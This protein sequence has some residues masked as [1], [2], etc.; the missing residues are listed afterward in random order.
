MGPEQILLVLILLGLTLYAVFGGADFGAGIWEFHT[1]FA[2]TERERSL[3]YRAV[4][5]V[6]EANHVWLIFVL[7]TLHSG[8]PRAFAAAGRALWV[9]L[10]FAMIGI[11]FRG[12]SFAFRSYADRAVRQRAVW[13][14]V[15]ALASIA[16]PFFLGAIVGAIASGRLAVTA[17]G[18]F[19]GNYLTGWISPLSIFTAFFAVG[20]CAYLAAVF[21]IR[22]AV[23]ASAADLVE[24]WRRRALVVAVTIGMLAAAGL[25]YVAA[26]APLLWEGFRSRA[27]PLVA[28][29]FVAGVFSL[30]AIWR[31]RFMAAD[32]GASFVVATVVWGWGVAQYPLIIP[33]TI[34]ID[35]AKGPA[36]VLRATVWAIAVGT[37]LIIPSLGFLLYLFKGK[38]P[39][40][41]PP[42]K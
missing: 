11:V 16:A 35:T 36:A 17:D 30:A 13:D 9:P 20:V 8:F 1:V 29:S 32:V 40:G 2:G 7:I 39:D 6:W 19:T 21:M 5:P 42:I 27:W 38:R 10:S 14:A 25:A 23:A 41:Q 18:D 28:A 22:E 4:G 37:I 24:V 33:P 15:F 3:I 31:R 26:A 12:A 34:S